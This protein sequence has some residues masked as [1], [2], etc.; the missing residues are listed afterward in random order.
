M[1]VD[2]FLEVKGMGESIT[3]ERMMETKGGLEEEVGC[4]P[5]ESEPSTKIDV[6]EIIGKI[7]DAVS[8]FREISAGAK[9]MEFKVDRLSFAVDKTEEEFTISFNSKIRI[10]PKV[11]EVSQ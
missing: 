6:T 5:V 9:E 3:S 7:S 2:G 11:A 10:K 8:K 4:V 1:F